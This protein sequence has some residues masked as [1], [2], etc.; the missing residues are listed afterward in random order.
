MYL[1][2]N[3]RDIFALDYVQIFVLNILSEFLNALMLLQ[4]LKNLIQ[5]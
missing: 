4:D 2:G 3:Y 5:D 1:L